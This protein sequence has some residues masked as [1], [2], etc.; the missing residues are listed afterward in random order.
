MSGDRDKCINAGMDDYITKPFVP[1]EIIAV[2]TRLHLKSDQGRHAS[3]MLTAGTKKFQ[4]PATKA[5]A[6]GLRELVSNHL[7]LVY[8]FTDDRLDAMVEVGIKTIDEHL[9]SFDK[10]IEAGA[11]HDLAFS[12]HALKGVL[13]NQGLSGQAE[14]A[15]QIELA[16]KAGEKAPFAEWADILRKN[17]QITP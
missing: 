13:L 3:A 9:G 4:P 2:L 15:R 16:A 14:L 17:L 8:G 11:W 7:Q 12:A 5:D 6:K 1:E 10:H